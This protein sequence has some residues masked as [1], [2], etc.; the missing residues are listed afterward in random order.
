M[1]RGD[2][3][4]K[5]SRITKVY[6]GVRALDQVDFE[7]KE[8]EIHAIVGENG[9][10]K[11]TLIKVLAGV[12]RP[13]EGSIEIDGET[14][15]Y[16][17]PK[18]SREKGIEVIYQ[19]YN[20][21]PTLSAAENICLGD[22][23]GRLVNYKAMEKTAGD[24]FRQFNIEIDPSTVVYKL[25]SAQMQIVEIAKAIS[26][27]VRVLIMDEPTAPL[28]IREVDI[29][30]EI[31]N[32]LKEQGVSILYISHRLDE[33]FAIADRVTIMR[34]GQYIET[35]EIQDVTRKE[36]I[37]LMVGRE[38]NEGHPQR[39]TRPGEEILRVEDLCGNGD[40][41]ISFSL[42]KGEI[43][44]VGGLVGC[45]RTEMAM[46]LY[47]AARIDSGRIF[48]NG[49]EVHIKSPKDAIAH[50]IG[51][52]P[53]DRK[54]QGCFLEMSINWN[55]SINNIKNISRGTVVDRKKEKEAATYYRNAMN[56]KTPSLE[57]KVKNL[58]GGNQQKVVIAK[59]L[60][61]DSDIIIF[62]EPTRGID[63][64]AKHEIYL[65]MNELVAQGKSILMIS[66]DMEELLGMS[67][68]I[69]VLSENT[70]AG[71]LKKEEFSQQNVL[72]LA[73]GGTDKPEWMTRRA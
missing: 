15:G 16:M 20:L 18:L 67:D 55:V 33:I 59:T 66:S 63:V 71:E 72:E 7:L 56:I 49:Q 14:Y 38:I 17:T 43:L 45:G 40:E 48:L 26:K 22:Q 13:E 30:M 37:S 62:D 65:L 8:A 41:H 70:F 3:L 6:P 11:S 2:T 31:I 10:G 12:I 35:R 27:N 4:V 47:G 46:M 36:L 29:L 68:R 50:G 73:S 19:E 64:N 1:A 54:R 21:V 69:I 42:Y 32:R 44:G 28:T 39:E 57:Q 52:I 5:L 53:E 61:A 23:H 51:L 25:S 34:D 9:A 58:S 60:A 24:I